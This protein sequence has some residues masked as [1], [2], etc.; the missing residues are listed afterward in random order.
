MVTD[1]KGEKI[2]T[3]YEEAYEKLKQFGQLHVLNYYEQLTADQQE[4]LLAQVMATDFSML[5][6]ASKEGE[7]A[8]QRGKIEPLAAMEL[9]EIARRR[10]EF[11]RIGLDAIR[12]GKV[13]QCCWPA[14]WAPDLALTIPRGCT[15]SD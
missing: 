8:A 3:N 11:T 6:F 5:S 10:E 9:D 1:Q 15:I 4:E 7:Q 2:M 13:G 14:V 12:A